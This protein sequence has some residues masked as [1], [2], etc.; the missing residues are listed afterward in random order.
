[1]KLDEYYLRHITP[2][3]NKVINEH[4]ERDF[5]YDFPLSPKIPEKFFNVTKV[6]QPPLNQGLTDQCTAFA[7]FSLFSSLLVGASA[8][9][10]KFLKYY[11]DS[12]AH[13]IGEMQ[14]NYV[15]EAWVKRLFR[16][17]IW[18]GRGRTLSA[19]LWSFNHVVELEDGSQLKIEEYYKF[20]HK[21]FIDFCR[22]I[23][24]EGGMAV[25]LM[26]HGD[27]YNWYDKE[28]VYIGKEENEDG[29]LVD[30]KFSGA[31]HALHVC[32]YD[33][34]RM[35]LICKGSY[36]AGAFQDGYQY[37]PAEKISHIG[38]ARIIRGCNFQ[39]PPV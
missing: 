16:A 32:G 34:Q 17:D 20:R 25:G 18:R 31:G 39:L 3:N 10:S 23:Y 1:M 21:E 12:T 4:D 28:G 11:S 9:Q 2:D 7:T 35:H 29:E 19:A 30:G 26:L 27:P 14:F 37:I 24:K 8:K 33:L 15:Q 38:D 13:Y 5:I 22:A 6:Q 36:G